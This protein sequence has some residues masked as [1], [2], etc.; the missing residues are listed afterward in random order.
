MVHGEVIPTA[1]DDLRPCRPQEDSFIKQNCLNTASRF[2]ILET[3]T[4]E[5]TASVVVKGCEDLP[6]CEDGIS[7]I[8]SDL[9]QIFCIPSRIS[10]GT[11][12][13]IIVNDKTW[14]TQIKQYAIYSPIQ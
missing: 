12:S 5:S 1:K 7:R 2:R 13:Y 11:H 6:V 8:K 10:L 3:I 14:A 4:E 9:L